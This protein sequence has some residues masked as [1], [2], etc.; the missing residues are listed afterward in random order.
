MRN[1]LSISRASLSLIVPV[2]LCIAALACGTSSPPRQPSPEAEPIPT[3]TQVEPDPT[4]EPEFKVTL[5]GDDLSKFRSLPVEFRDA[6][7][8]MHASVKRMGELAGKD[9]RNGKADTDPVAGEEKASPT[10]TSTGPVETSAT[11]TPAEEAGRG[12]DG[13]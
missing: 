10:D 1:S 12:L 5:R 4:A 3:A 7:E 8:Q 9:T 13:A 6:L 2:V 11:N